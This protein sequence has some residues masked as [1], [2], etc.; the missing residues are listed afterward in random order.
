M[1]DAKLKETTFENTKLGTVP[2]NWQ[3][4]YFT[5]CPMVSANNIDQERWKKETTAK[6]PEASVLLATTKRLG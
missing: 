1:A 2:L 3:E 6:L 5:N 4:V